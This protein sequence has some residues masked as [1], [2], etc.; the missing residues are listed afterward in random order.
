MHDLK[1]QVL[2]VVACRGSHTQPNIQTRTSRPQPDIRDLIYG[3][4]M[5]TKEI[6][7]DWLFGLGLLAGW[8]IFAPHMDTGLNYYEAFWYGVAFGGILYLGSR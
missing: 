5:A 4:D 1:L 8:T 3:L 7:P 6:I 2:C